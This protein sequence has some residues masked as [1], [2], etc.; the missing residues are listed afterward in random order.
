[1]KLKKKEKGERGIGIYLYKWNSLIT[2]YIMNY[3]EQR[4]ADGK[5]DGRV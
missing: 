3:T 4:A 1:M 2:H 5:N